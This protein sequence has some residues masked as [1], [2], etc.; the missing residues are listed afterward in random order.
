[1]ILN[2]EFAFTFSEKKGGATAP[3]YLIHAGVEPLKFTNL[4]P[5]WEPDDT[6]TE[7]AQKVN[8]CFQLDICKAALGWLTG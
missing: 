3:A 8:N 2:C 7:I 1:M 6:V 5:Y 4:F